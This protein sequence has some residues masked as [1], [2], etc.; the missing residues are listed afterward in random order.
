ME[1][2]SKSTEPDAFHAAS[3]VILK[4]STRWAASSNFGSI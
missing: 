3:S 1:W 2:P 4:E